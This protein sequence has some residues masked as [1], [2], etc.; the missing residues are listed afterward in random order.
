MLFKNEKK[1]VK[2]YQTIHFQS[3]MSKMYKL[4]IKIRYMY[5]A[6][7]HL[8]DVVNQLFKGEVPRVQNPTR[9][10]FVAY[11]AGFTWYKPKQFYHNYKNKK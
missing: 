8:H 1:D 5:L 7:D 2:S 3:K 4:L 11:E 10:V 6:T 9:V